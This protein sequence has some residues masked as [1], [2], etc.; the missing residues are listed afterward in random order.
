M[1]TLKIKNMADYVYIPKFSMNPNTMSPAHFRKYNSINGFDALIKNL[2]AAILAMSLNSRKGLIQCAKFI[3]RDVEKTMPLVPV[4]TTNLQKSWEVHFINDG[5]GI[6]K[7]YGVRFGYS[8][9]YALWVHEMVGDINWT[10]EG[11]GAKWLER[12]INRNH[13]VLMQIIAA[14]II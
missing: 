5:V 12:S 2:N 3:Q 9:N 4:D 6:G 11:S 14:S 8:A 7:K 10:R 1:V 13:D